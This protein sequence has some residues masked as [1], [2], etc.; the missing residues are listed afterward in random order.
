MT[1]LAITRILRTEDPDQTR[2]VS[3]DDFRELTLEDF[4]RLYPAE[5]RDYET[6]CPIKSLPSTVMISTSLRC[7]PLGDL[8][9]RDIAYLN[10]SVAILRKLDIS[11]SDIHN[12][13]IMRRNGRPVLIDW[14]LSQLNAKDKDLLERDTKFLDAARLQNMNEKRDRMRREEE[15]LVRAQREAERQAEREAQREAGE[16]EEP[17]MRRMRLK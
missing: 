5:A 2:F 11:H 17:P 6:E 13:N 10:E 1:E 4:R 16:D 8:T 14:G 7:D 12:K 15:A 3:S 9:P